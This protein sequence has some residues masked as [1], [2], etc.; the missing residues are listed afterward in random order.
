MEL[1]MN[2]AVGQPMIGESSSMGSVKAYLLKVASTDSNVLITGESG[3]GKELVAELIHR[4]SARGQKPLVCLNC[5]ALPDSLLESELFGFERGAFTGA[6]SRNP[7]KLQQADGGTVFFDEVGD[8][9]PYA[10]AKVLRLLESKQLQRLGANQSVSLNIRVVAATNQDLEARMAEGKFRRDLY[11]R[12]NVARIHLP[13][14]RERK[15]DL[16]LLLEHYLREFN[17]RSG[18]RV[19]GFAQEA[20]EELLSYDWPGN[21]RELKNL[22]EAAFIN[23]DADNPALSQRICLQDLPEPFRSRLTDR[24]ADSQGERDRLLTALLATRWNKSK[25]AQRLQWSRMTLYRK[26]AKYHLLTKPE[27]TEEDRTPLPAG[28]EQEQA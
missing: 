10:Q 23:L 3:T 12:L 4:H 8:M 16:P 24:E 5:A 13:P 7:G 19:E 2:Q 14:L 1:L 21:I 6:H 18:T 17:N 9:S 28:S 25:A 22:V 11:F 27:T 26:L 20:L 15:E